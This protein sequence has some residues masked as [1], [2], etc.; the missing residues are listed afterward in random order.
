MFSFHDKSI[1]IA[2]FGLYKIRSISSFGFAR[3]TFGYIACSG[4]GLDTVGLVNIPAKNDIADFVF[5]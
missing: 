3:R 1:I 5:V 2:L 4:L